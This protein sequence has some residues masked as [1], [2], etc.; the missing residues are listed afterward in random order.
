VY[1]VKP[2]QTVAMHTITVG[3]TDANSSAVQ[4]LDPGSIVAIDNFDKLQD[5]MKVTARPGTSGGASQN[6]RTGP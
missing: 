5:G 2:D 1:Q 6:Q 4:G 3:T